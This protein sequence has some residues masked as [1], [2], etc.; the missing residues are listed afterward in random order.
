MTGLNLIRNRIRQFFAAGDI[1]ILPVLKFILAFVLLT[2]LNRRLGYLEILTSTFLVVLLSVL[3][4]IMPIS[5]MAIVGAIFIVLHCFGLSMMTGA[6]AAAMYL[7]ILILVL[8]FVPKDAPVLV[9]GP[10]ASLIGVPCAVPL[11]LGLTGNAASA[12]SAMVSVVSV[13]FLKQ[14]PAAGALLQAGEMTNLEVLQS[15]LENILL[16]KEMVLSIVIAAATVL[17]VVLLKRLLT[18]YTWLISVAGGAAAYLILTMVGSSVL[19]ESAP[20]VPA[21]LKNVLL[22]L[23]IGVVMAFFMHSLDYSRA[24]NVQFEDDEYYY[25]VKAVPKNV[26]KIREEEQA[27]LDEDDDPDG[28]RKGLENTLQDL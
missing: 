26:G 27:A 21:L 3:C 17:A 22:S 2:V 9:L 14:L 23:V 11:G 24:K 8:R 19:L 13:S 12:F 7:L 20:E 18:N 1:Y 28:Y 6:V 15:L 5:G 16:S 10:V 25:Y 4:A